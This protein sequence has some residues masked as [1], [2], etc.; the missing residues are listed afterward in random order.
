MLPIIPP[1]SETIISI[2]YYMPVVSIVSLIGLRHLHGPT[3][4]EYPGKRTLSPKCKTCVRENKES[5]GSCD[6]RYDC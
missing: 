2:T 4:G 5:D 1:H 6:K 3:G